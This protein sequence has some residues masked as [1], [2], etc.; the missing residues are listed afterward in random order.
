[1]LK[2]RCSIG[3]DRI[4]AEWGIHSTLAQGPPKNN[5]LAQVPQL[6]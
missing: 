3:G 6:G 2:W 5:V 1:M 4:R